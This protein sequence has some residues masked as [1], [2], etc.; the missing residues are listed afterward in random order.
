MISLL[1]FLS[2]FMFWWVLCLPHPLSHL[3]S[4]LF[5]GSCPCCPLPLQPHFLFTWTCVQLSYYLFC[6]HLPCW[7]TCA[8][9]TGC[10]IHLFEALVKS[11]VLTYPIALFLFVMTRGP[12]NIPWAY[13]IMS[14]KRALEL[15][16]KSRRLT[17]ADLEMWPMGVGS[18]WE[19]GV[20]S[21]VSGVSEVAWHWPCLISMSS[22][23]TGNSIIMWYLHSYKPKLQPGNHPENSFLDKTGRWKSCIM[24]RH[25]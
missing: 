11:C 1:L 15:R 3:V 25:V 18:L 8:M 22:K 4:G 19:C 14:V 7:G 10:K 23:A 9:Y 21:C 20:S 6:G 16:R 24:R 2:G 5:E 17:E 12:S 13:A